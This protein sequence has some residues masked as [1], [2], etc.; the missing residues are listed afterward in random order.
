MSYKVLKGYKAN[1]SNITEVEKL[2][3]DLRERL[4][5]RAKE[6][7]LYL[8]AR[9]IESINDDVAMDKMKRPQSIYQM[10]LE[11]LSIKIKNASLKQLPIEYNLNINVNILMNEDFVFFKVNSNN[12]IYDEVFKKF[13]MLEEYCVSDIDIMYSS[14]TKSKRWAELIKNYE[15]FQPMGITLISGREDFFKDIQLSDLQFIKA[16]E[17]LEVLT[18]REITTRLLNMYSSCSQINPNNQIN[19]IKLMEYLDLSL[20]RLDSNEVM[21]EYN[22]IRK[23]LKPLIIEIDIN[24]IM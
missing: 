10:A 4:F 7:C 21:E 22:E 13:S 20:L 12:F 1:I 9:E 17:R 18:R 3:R 2:L 19:P 8:L 5:E 14:D 11:M 15:E 24:S 6:E 23:G 16:S